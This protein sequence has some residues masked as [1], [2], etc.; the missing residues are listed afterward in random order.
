MGTALAV[1][2]LDT[3]TVIPLEW[4]QGSFL[5]S[6]KAEIAFLWFLSRWLLGAVRKSRIPQGSRR[7]L[8]KNSDSQTTTDLS[9][10]ASEAC[11]WS[12]GTHQ[13][14]LCAQEWGHSDE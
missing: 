7:D 10:G 8:Y 14:E 12:W 11:S 3:E 6:E 5:S 13:P 1:I 4:M 9:V 2:P